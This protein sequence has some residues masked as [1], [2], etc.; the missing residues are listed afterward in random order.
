MLGIRV[1]KFYL[2]FNPWFSLYKRKIGNVEFG[3]G[4]LPLGG[5]VSI[6]DS[7]EKLFNEES[8]LK[9]SLKKAKS[10]LRKSN[11]KGNEAEAMVWREKVTA[12]EADIARVKEELRTLTPEPDE[13][14]AKPA[15]KRLIVM[16]AGV[17][18]N[19]VLAIVVFSGILFTWG[20]NYYHN[21]DMKHGY[22]F[23]QQAEELG[24]VDGDKILTLNNK[25]VGNFSELR[26]GLL[27][28]ED[29]TKVEVLRGQD[30]V[31]I[32]IPMKQITKIRKSR[33]YNDFIVP[34]WPFEVIEA[35]SK[36]AI[37]AG[38]VAGDRII[39]IDSIATPDYITGINTLHQAKLKSVA[40]T[41]VRDSQVAE[42]EESA[43]MADVEP[44]MAL[45]RDTIVLNAPVNKD[46]QL[47]VNV[48]L[49]PMRHTDYT[50]VESIPAGVKLAFK[51][52]KSYWNQLVMMVNPN[53]ELYSEV[54]GF[55][56]IG[57][58]FPK[59]W[60]WYS[61]WHITAL[62]SVM[63]AVMNLLPIPVLDGGHVLFALY[64][65]ITRRKPSDK[66]LEVAQTIGFA[67]LMLLIIYANGNDL[68]NLFK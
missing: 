45:Q 11:R 7:R 60:D 37:D 46:G 9:D 31:A 27:L 20:E 57:S 17:F 40:V 24:F 48:A 49:P 10:E 29:D 47:G 19:V 54:G 61:F 3:L 12:I 21:D 52:I 14:R 1:D 42:T 13:L 65:I 62:I 68:F 5:Y 56:S 66:F 4:W 22:V 43:E 67:L 25:E 55:I 23:N 33:K 44:R 28:V 58:I 50:M 38:F 41:V 18:M 16:V 53:T 36:S 6:Y 30:T 64:E 39:A 35:K 34:N 8:E 59:V 2:F 63:L 51:E 26:M 15:W 32:N